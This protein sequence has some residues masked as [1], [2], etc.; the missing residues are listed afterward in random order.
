M[1]VIV[2]HENCFLT[3][4]VRIFA[5]FI[6]RVKIRDG[7]LD[8]LYWDTCTWYWYQVY[9]CCWKSFGE[10]LFAVIRIWCLSSRNVR[11]SVNQLWK[12]TGIYYFLILINVCTC[13][14]S[15][16]CWVKG[17]I[18]GQ[19]FSNFTSIF[20]C[21]VTFAFG[22]VLFQLKHFLPSV[23]VV[24]SNTGKKVEMGGNQFN[25]S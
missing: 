11:V 18:H 17:L 13:F 23:A 19:C 14:L 2:L 24:G 9:F 8:R 6:L 3:R 22:N 20:C 16:Q 5:C 21:Y 4:Q 10:R 15:G 25:G 12:F 7:E 1:V